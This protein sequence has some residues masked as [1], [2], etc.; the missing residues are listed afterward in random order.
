MMVTMETGVVPENDTI[1]VFIKILPGTCLNCS[2]LTNAV[3]FFQEDF[4]TPGT[5]GDILYEN[6]LFDIP[7]LMDICA[8]Y[9]GEESKNTPLLRKMMDNIFSKQPK[10]VLISI[11]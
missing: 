1:S 2:V 9:G 3:W 8:L 11:V 5:F 4:M 10:L 6:F 7:K